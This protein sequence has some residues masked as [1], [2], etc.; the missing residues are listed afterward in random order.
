MGLRLSAGHLTRSR[1]SHAGL[2]SGMPSR[3]APAG[4]QALDV[5]ARGRPELEHLESCGR[6]TGQ[7]LRTPRPASTSPAIRSRSS[8]ETKMVS[9]PPGFR[10]GPM[11][12]NVAP[13]GSSTAASSEPH[14]RMTVTSSVIRDR[15]SGSVSAAATRKMTFGRPPLRV[16][17]AARRDASASALASASR[18]R[19]KSPARA[20]RVA[21]RPSRIRSRYR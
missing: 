1:Y 10:T 5:C 2:R 16:G 15:S 17:R 19:T 14:G 11:P 13:S 9:S 20:P 4:R 8:A 12:A 18:A 21:A 7:R 3:F 6:I